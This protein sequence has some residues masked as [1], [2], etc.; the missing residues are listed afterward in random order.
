MTG[1]FTEG[2]WQ[3]DRHADGGLTVSDFGGKI[4]TIERWRI[5]REFN[6]RAIAALPDLFN[7]LERLIW[8]T[9]GICEGGYGPEMDKAFDNARAALTKARGGK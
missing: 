5:E 7:S 6:A 2:P 8:A 3:V 4:A 1:R 9:S